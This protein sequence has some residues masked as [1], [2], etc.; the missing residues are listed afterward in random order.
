MFF[1]AVFYICLLCARSELKSTPYPFSPVQQIANNGQPH[2]YTL[3]TGPPGSGPPQ[4]HLPPGAHHL[5]QPPPPSA[6]SAHLQQHSPSPPSA[7]AQQ[8]P[9]SAAAAAAAAAAYHKDERSQR[10]HNKLLRKLDAKNREN[11][12]QAQRKGGPPQQPPPHIMVHINHNNGLHHHNSGNNHHQQQHNSNNSTGGGMHNNHTAQNNHHVH[13]QQQLQHQQQHPHQQH[14]NHNVIHH[15]SN[16]HQHIHQQQQQQQQS[17][18][19]QQQT[20]LHNQHNQLHGHHHHHLHVV[21]G[22]APPSPHNGGGTTHLSTTPTSG[23]AS[24]AS[25]DEDTSSL[26]TTDD[27]DETLAL[28]EHLSSVPPP[29]VSE[30]TSRTALVQWSAPQPPSEPPSPTTVSPPSPAPSPSPPPPP[31]STTAAEQSTADTVA[32]ATTTVATAAVVSSPPAPT[33]NARDLRYEVLLSDRGKEGKYK[34]IF[35]GASLTCRIRD[36]RPGQEYSVCLVVHLHNVQGSASEAAVFTT[37]G[38][39]PDAP[40]PPKCIA[41]TKNSLQL[42]WNAPVD[43]GAHIQQYLLEFDEGKTG[44]TADSG[45]DADDDVTAAVG[46]GLAVAPVIPFVEVI[47][48]KG[49]QYSLS[50]L[51]PSTWYQFRLAAINEF[52]HSTYSDPVA[53]ATAGNVPPP[54]PAPQVHPAI[55]TSSHLRLTW[56]RRPTDDDYVLQ[57]ADPGSGHGFL[58][59]YTGRDTQ[60]DCTQLHRA[61]AY[62]FRIRA[63][64]ESGLSGW[65]EVVTAATLPERPGRPGRPAV[66]GRTHA[67]QF[68]ARWDA[69]SDNGGAAVRLYTLQMGTAESATISAAQTAATTMATVYTGPDTEAQCDGLQPGRVYQLRVCCEGPGGI[70]VFSDSALITTEAVVPDAPAA[71]QCTHAPGPYA[72]ALR[73][74][75]PDWQGGAAVT[76]FELQ[77]L[78]LAAADDA[79]STAAVSV[80]RGKEPQCCVRD[81]QP[82]AAYSAQVRAF[83]RIGA[84]SWSEAL[85]FSAGAAAPFAPEQPSVEIAPV[86]G[87]VTVTWRE[88]IANGSVIVEYQ[89]EAA[90]WPQP[91]SADDVS[92]VAGANAPRAE[93]FHACYTGLAAS[94]NVRHLLPY[95]RYA[96]RVCARNAAGTSL[97]STV[98]SVRTPP[99]VP[100]APHIEGHQATADTIRLQWRAAEANGSPVLY[101][102]VE[103]ATT[104]AA[105]TSSATTTA[106]SLSSQ[107]TADAQPEWTVRQLRPETTYRYRVQA[108]NACGPGPFSNAVRV[109]T[110]ALPPRAPRLECGQPQAH[111]AL[112]LR[113][114]DGKNVDFTRFV[115]D[116]WNA[117]AGEFQTVY[118]GKLMAFK[119]GKLQEQQAYVFRICA[120]SDAAGVGDWSEEYVFRTAAAVPSSVR[121]PRC[122]DAGCAQQQQR[123]QPSATDGVGAESE[124]T[125]ALGKP[126]WVAAVQVDWQHSRNTFAD[127]V[128]YVLQMHGPRA[129]EFKQVSDRRPYVLYFPFLINCLQHP[130]LS[131][132]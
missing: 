24:T 40:L 27:D 58:T 125:A 29:V 53:Y 86:G 35:K 5:H 109:Q 63:Q 18:L 124:T 23:A 75:L 97:Y 15:H 30:V 67:T 69:P 81:L 132:S 3:P 1:C 21:G 110:R 17:A 93:H 4:Y 84:G 92:S 60:H 26:A 73:W 127:P 130:D 78:A 119:V 101:Y 31:S 6:M 100:A 87:H 64:N 59:C 39:E 89:L 116:M 9:T 33:L 120:E 106:S 77:L 105:A 79:T 10:Q 70:S 65:S 111:N 14:L 71:P 103:D 90:A 42:R 11:Q 118:A 122:T 102:I 113:W 62:Q 49:K 94:A 115:L 82:G 46:D 76:E 128:E 114:S 107:R 48:M 98:A 25:Y 45:T 99:T 104:A 19:H 108:V 41:R 61:T 8:P 22:S 57:I 44:R 96:F 43:N 83:N 117:R 32:P 55:T 131:R 12:Q 47:R 7:A 20:P 80:Y 37:P 85:R 52:G 126:E 28:Q 16:H 38:C 68:K 95:T 56:T 129:F 2:Y 121:A 66:K 74:L 51:Q 13:L 36:L 72:A 88:P 91:D 123:G 54:M 50:K 112:K 34:I